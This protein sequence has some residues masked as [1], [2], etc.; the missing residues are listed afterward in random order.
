MIKV[1]LT[2][3]QERKACWELMALKAYFNGRK[4]ISLKTLLFDKNIAMSQRIWLAEKF[5]PIA[6]RQAICYWFDA[7][8][9]RLDQWSDRDIYLR[10]RANREIWKMSMF[11]P[12]YYSKNGWA[13]RCELLEKIQEIVQ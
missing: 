6:D 2:A 4:W 3:L 11:A 13:K 5:L 8:D 9:L 7:H 1:T 12:W 10:S